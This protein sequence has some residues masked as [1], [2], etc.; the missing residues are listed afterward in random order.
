[1]HVII[2]VGTKRFNY[3]ESRE[4]YDKRKYQQLP[5]TTDSGRDPIEPKHNG[6]GG[7][8]HSSYHNRHNHHYS[9]AI[10]YRQAAPL[11]LIRIINTHQK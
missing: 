4:L 3:L 1:L 5:A 10:I 9:S 2:V 8:A 7:G 6:G 11:L